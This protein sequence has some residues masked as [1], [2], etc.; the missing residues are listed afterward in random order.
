MSFFAKTMYSPFKEYFKRFN[1]FNQ[2]S[3]KTYQNDYNIIFNKLPS[4]LTFPFS[5]TSFHITL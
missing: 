1:L 2:S 4:T 5:T 3:K